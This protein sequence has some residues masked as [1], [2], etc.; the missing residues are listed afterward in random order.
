MS[1]EAFCRKHRLKAEDLRFWQQLAGQE[2]S[3]KLRTMGAAEKT[4]KPEFAFYTREMYFSEKTFRE[5]CAKIIELTSGERP[6]EKGSV[7]SKK[8]AYCELTRYR[9]LQRIAAL[10]SDWDS[11]EFMTWVLRQL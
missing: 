4:I 1:D 3:A 8:D 6:S 9:L 10:P 2:L 11:N 5:E 7:R